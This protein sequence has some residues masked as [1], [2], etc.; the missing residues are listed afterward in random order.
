MMAEYDGVA[1]DWFESESELMEAM[2]SNEMASLGEILVKDEKKFID[3][4]ASCAFIVTE[5]QY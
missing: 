4:T 3:H 1:E 5:V 2:S